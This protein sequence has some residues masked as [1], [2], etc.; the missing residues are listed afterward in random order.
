M[1]MVGNRPGKKFETEVD[2]A[3]CIINYLEA[4]GWD[5]YQEVS[6]GQGYPSCDIVGVYEGL[7]WAI[8]T[9]KTFGL[10]VLE[11]ANYWRYRA[12][13]VSV[14]IPEQTSSYSKRSTKFNVTQKLCDATG[15]GILSASPS[16]GSSHVIEK[17]KFNRKA[18]C[19]SFKQLCRPELKTSNRAGE[20][21]KGKT[22]VFSVFRDD[23]IALVAKKPGVS[24][25]D[26]I[27]EIGHHYSSD[28]TAK[29]CVSRYISQG[30]I[31]GIENRRGK[32]LFLTK[33]NI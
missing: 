10:Q 15:I 13:F 28:G 11:Q 16:W 18:N 32:G 7:Y 27:E 33:S 9:K 22:S 30:V 26:A 14:G 21:S 24:M 2:L 1:A 6:H 25:K 23:L 19:Y 20:P 8:E 3:Q 5:V 4:K 17:A 29:A 12:H 31:P